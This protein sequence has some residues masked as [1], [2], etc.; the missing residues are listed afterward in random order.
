M[1]CSREAYV[2]DIEVLLEAQHETRIPVL[3]SSAGG[4]GTNLHVDVFR[5]I[6]AEIA[7]RRGWRFKLASIYADIDKAH[8]SRELKAGRIEPL[9]PVPPSAAPRPRWRPIHS[10]K[11]PIPS[12]W[13][14]PAARSICR[15]ANTSR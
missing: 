12:G 13:P 14:A 1:T 15:N 11:R 8:I 4:D 6:I 2:K 10:T 3:I 7:K 9:G 5:D